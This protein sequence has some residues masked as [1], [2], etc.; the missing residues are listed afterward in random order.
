MGMRVLYK[1]I[2]YEPIETVLYS[3][4]VAGATVTE[5]VESTYYTYACYCDHCGCVHLK[6]QI[7]TGVQYGQLVKALIWGGLAF[8]F[9]FCPF[10]IFLA[11]DDI[12]YLFLKSAGL[13]LLVA[14][15]ILGRSGLLEQAFSPVCAATCTAC[16]RTFGLDFR[17]TTIMAE[18][19]EFPEDVRPDRRFPRLRKDDHR[20]DVGR[21]PGN[22]TLG[23]VIHVVS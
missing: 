6:T 16:G 13:G 9:G 14:M 18:G 12:S 15:T 10:Y 19:V 11:V 20:S 8:L 4:G 23:Q 1:G 7:R 21:V 22:P 3:A 17:S 2:S 5:T